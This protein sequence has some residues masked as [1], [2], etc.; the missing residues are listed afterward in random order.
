MKVDGKHFCVAHTYLLYLE[1]QRG[2]PNSSQQG[3]GW[4]ERKGWRESEG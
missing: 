3:I 1:D 2:L 4:K